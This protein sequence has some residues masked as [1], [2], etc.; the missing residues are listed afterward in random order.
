MT[1]V[2][3]ETDSQEC[4]R[5]LET[6]HWGRL[7]YREEDVLYFPRGLLGFEACRRWAIFTS[8]E[9]QPFLWMVSID[10]PQIA[11]VIL[12]PLLVVP[13]YRPA[14][15][16]RDLED[17][18]AE[19]L[20]DLRIFSIVTLGKT[21]ETT[22]INLSGPLVINIRK[23]LGKQVALLSNKYTTKHPLIAKSE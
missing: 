7:R 13:D 2:Q 21:V 1:E 3:G 20:E 15:C 6:L 11:F 10:D 12:D 23:K 4:W 16:Q 9:H 22:T 17:L 19:S 8:E 5:E 14:F 18:E